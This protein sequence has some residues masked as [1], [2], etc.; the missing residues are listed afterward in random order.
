MKSYKTNG[1]M[2]ER[3]LKEIRDALFRIETHLKKYEPK[4]EETT[5]QL[6]ND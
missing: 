4:K 5:K 6:L 2:T 1:K 3:L